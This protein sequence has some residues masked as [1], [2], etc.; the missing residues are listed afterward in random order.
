MLWDIHACK[1]WFFFLEVI[2]SQSQHPTWSVLPVI[3]ASFHCLRLVLGLLWFFLGLWLSVFWT[4]NALPN[5]LL[6]Y[7]ELCSLLRGFVLSFSLVIFGLI[8]HEWVWK[9][10]NL[11]STFGSSANYVQ[12]I[13]IILGAGWA[14]G[15][16]WWCHSSRLGIQE[17][18]GE[19]GG[20]GQSLASDERLPLALM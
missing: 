1:T 8:T 10:I 16:H 15:A 19:G 14:Q 7:T 3:S 20:L 13:M 9:K 12:S 4:W 17:G 18:R 6:F 2:F 5:V 11:Y